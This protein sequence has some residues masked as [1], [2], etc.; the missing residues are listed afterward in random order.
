[1]RMQ[2]LVG[3]R[4]RRHRSAFTFVELMAVIG[5]LALLAGLLMVAAQALRTRYLGTSCQNNLAQI[6]F[7][8]QTYRSTGQPLPTPDRLRNTLYT[9]L[10]NR[11]DVFTCPAA[12]VSSSTSFGTNF[13]L[14]FFQPI[15]NKIAV[16]D[17]VQGDVPFIGGSY[18]DFQHIVSARHGYSANALYY[19]G[20]VVPYMIA[21]INPYDPDEGSN[22]VD[23]Y[24]KPAC[25]DCSGFGR[26]GNGSN[27]STYSG[28]NGLTATYFT[29]QD[30]T[31]L[32]STRIETSMHLPFG[33]SEAYGVAYN[34]PLPT[35]SANAA[36]AFS[37]K[38]TGKI[39]ASTTDTYTFYL[40]VDNEGEVYI[41][42]ALILQRVAG[43]WDGVGGV[44]YVQASGPVPLTAGVPVPIEI[45]CI[46]YGGPAHITV[47]WSSSSS[48][49]PTDI[50]LANMIPQ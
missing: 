49:I 35:A 4:S 26:T 29:N 33:A 27:G 50:P 46:N 45:H 22:N 14:S 3:E 39:V 48:P 47:Q 32:S 11:P 17:A 5:V 16:I 30:F 41:N 28:P 42:G 13:C 6:G 1:M 38:F 23:K 34:I 18:S 8:L 10:E 19:D 43:G 12:A 31:G 25:G 24:W 37:A 15:D 21:Q 20:H 9:Y 36:P 44:L 7:A 2:R 40:C